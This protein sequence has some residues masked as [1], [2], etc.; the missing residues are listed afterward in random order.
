MCGGAKNVI[1]IN[2]IKYRIVMF[3]INRVLSQ[4]SRGFFEAKS[5]LLNS[6]G[7]HIGKGTRIVGPIEANGHLTI[8]EN[9]WIGKNL[10]INGNGYVV[11]QSIAPGTDVTD[12]MKIELELSPKFDAEITT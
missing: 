6:I 12:N 7:Y 5:R 11:N 3:L 2:G 8:G 4:R 9:C 10:R 1:G